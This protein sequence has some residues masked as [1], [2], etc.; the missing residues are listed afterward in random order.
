MT[1]PVN[2][3]GNGQG[4]MTVERLREI[5]DAYGASPNRWP[6]EERTA[7]VL[8]LDN[9]E[10]ARAA[11]AEAM[12]LDIVLDHANAP[13]PSPGL[14]ERLHRQ[15][16]KQRTLWARIAAGLPGW[17]TGSGT[18]PVV[19]RPI[20]FALTMALGVLIGVAFPDGGDPGAGPDRTAQVAPSAGEPADAGGFESAGTAPDRSIPVLA[21]TDI[22]DGPEADTPETPAVETNGTGNSS[23]PLDDIP[24]I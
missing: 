3:G 20:A 22:V 4:E 24:L 5:L 12:R 1:D 6:P 11:H 7:A 21:L 16:A 13:P 9:S 18:Q 10:D 19:M 23:G 8:L 14:A 15:G 17:L 2:Q